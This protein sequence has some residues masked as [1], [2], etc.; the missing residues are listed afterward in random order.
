MDTIKQ[1]PKPG[2]VNKVI[3][4]W[5]TIAI[6]A[7]MC[8]V[9]VTITFAYLY[10]TEIKAQSKRAYFV[11]PTSVYEGEIQHTELIN[12]YRAKDHVRKFI[13]LFFAHDEESFKSRIEAGLHLIEKEA[14]KELYY[15]FVQAK[16]FESYQNYHVSNKVEIDSISVNTNVVPIQG[17]AYFKQVLVL[18]S[19][20]K[21]ITPIAFKF[22]LV[23]TG[24]SNEFN[25]AGLEIQKLVH[26]DYELPTDEVNNNNSK[27]EPRIDE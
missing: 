17:R 21:T 7:L 13:S 10:T 1:N 24:F 16:V 27:A 6:I 23:P 19:R 15:Q 26:I 12:Y 18:P 9:I 5:K 22:Q 11:T 25:S 14:G 3:K 20:E 2:E 4:A 8:L